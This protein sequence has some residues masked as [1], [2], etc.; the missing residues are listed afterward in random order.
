M[1][2]ALQGGRAG[3]QKLQNGG[4][5]YSLMHARTHAHTDGRM[6]A[7]MHTITMFSLLIHC[8][9]SQCRTSLAAK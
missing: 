5:V 8:C 3:L 9:S 6:H 4:V 7:R 2:Q 1:I